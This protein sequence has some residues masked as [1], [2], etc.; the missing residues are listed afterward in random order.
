[1]SVI[2]SLLDDYLAARGLQRP[3]GASARKVAEEA[4]ELVEACSVTAPDTRKVAHELADV[5]LAAAVVA[6][7]YGFT[8]EDAI[9]QKMAHDADRE[10]PVP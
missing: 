6:E 8:V 4:I 5:V 3:S 10:R 1:M 2:A 9:R 7:H